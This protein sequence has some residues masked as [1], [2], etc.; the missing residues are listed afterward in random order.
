MKFDKIEFQSLLFNVNKPS[1][2]I[3]HEI[4]TCHKTPGLGSVNFCLAFPDVYEVGMSHL[5]LKIL[6]SI[7]NAENDAMADRVY[8]PWVDF[9]DAL[10]KNNI[11]LFGVESK[12]AVSDFDILG[13]T[14]QSELNFSNIL[15]MLDLAKI[16]LLSKDRRDHDPVVITG[17]PCATNPGTLSPFIDAFL[18]GEGEEAIIEIKDAMAAHKNGSR[19]DKLLALEKIEGM[20]VPSVVERNSYP[21]VAPT[22]GGSSPKFEVRSAKC[23]VQNQNNVALTTAGSY[24]VP[25]L[26]GSS[27][28]TVKIRKYAGFPDYENT[29]DKQLI[30][31]QHA[32]HDRYVAEIMRGCTRG[33]RFCHAGFFYRPVRERTP[34]QI[35]E[36]I[37][38]EVKEA[39]WEEAA[40]VSLSS[41]DYTCIRPLLLALHNRLKDNKA[42]ISLPS[43]RVDSLDNEL[44]QLINAVG[45][46]GL[47]VAPEAGSQR[48]RDSIN[49]NITEEEILHGVHIA[50]ENGW[51]LMKLYFMVGLPGEEDSDIEAI[52]DLVEDIIAVS[53]KKLQIN[54]SLS[55]FV[56]KP[57]TPFQWAGM[58]SP[59]MLLKRVLNVKH[60][61][62]RYRFVKVKYH[63]IES[64]MMEAILCRGDADT[65][66]WMLEA[67]KLG[68]KFDGWHEYFDFAYYEQAGINLNYDWHKILQPIPTDQKLPWDNI[69]IGVTNE[70]LLR[71]WEKSQ[72]GIKTGDCKETACLDCGVCDSHIHMHLAREEQDANPAAPVVPVVLPS[73][74]EPTSVSKS[75]PTP[76]GTPPSP[77]TTQYRVFYSKM[78]D[79]RFISHLDLMR[80]IFR[81]VR[82]HHLPVVYTQGYN[83]HPKISL[84]PPLPLGTEGEMEFFDITFAYEIPHDELATLFQ[85]N[86]EGA[87]E[88]REVQKMEDSD[89]INWE[90]DGIEM[91]E[92]TPSSDM[93]DTFNEKTRLFNESGSFPI[94][95]IKKE[96]ETT[97]ELKEI[98]LEMHWKNGVLHLKKKLKGAGVYDVLKQVFGLERSETFGMR[99]CRKCF[100]I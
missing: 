92:I 99:I 78:G 85:K 5:G 81:L 21:A 15:Y 3:D 83:P 38:E 89:K 50:L 40:L 73:V 20:Y 35:I 37:L 6:Y 84:G 69:H 9:G 48:L 95:R 25:T 70:Y 79:L 72:S 82:R 98:I 56:P 44:V 58:L 71:E 51:Q 86:F 17:G 57:F 10:K 39:G 8:A 24:V 13:F 87:I 61:L 90:A 4:N 14:L 93:H 59:E 75:I 18:I 46:G 80:M 64:S 29:H 23:E 68:A 52:I 63:E 43:L 76:G 91:L 11:P 97:S 34:E 36:H 60:A 41:S 7:L 100:S 62:S 67:Y 16:P 22:S 30:A 1:R 65:G 49:K 19:S 77:T 88:F 74:I 26:G 96:K 45:K 47:T 33:C 12:V 94:T 31:W 53:R 27:K 66:M 32:T 28:H 54:V 42:T 2:Y 55:P